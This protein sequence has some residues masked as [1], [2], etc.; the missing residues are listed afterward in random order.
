MARVQKTTWDSM[1]YTSHR[2]P[3]IA[4]I[5]LLPLPFLPPLVRFCAVVALAPVCLLLS[6]FLRKEVDEDSRQTSNVARWLLFATL[7]LFMPSLVILFVYGATPPAYL[8]VLFFK[9]ILDMLN[10]ANLAAIVM[11]LVIF[12]GGMVLY[13][14]LYFLIA[15]G[16]ARLICRGRS[17]RYALTVVPAICIVLAG[18]AAMPIYITFGDSAP[19]KYIRQ[20]KP[21]IV[22][23]A[24][25]LKS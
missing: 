11:G 25:L 3:I 9:M 14:T 20:A 13:G 5:C 17:N 8:P 19:S 16:M 10:T 7:M 12:G 18:S 6:R 21:R 15:S 1:N 24:G 22:N 4:A 23:L 2:G